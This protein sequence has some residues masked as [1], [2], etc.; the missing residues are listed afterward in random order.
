MK[1]KA[2]GSLTVTQLQSRLDS[3]NTLWS[4]ANAADTD[5]LCHNTDPTDPYLDEVILAQFHSTY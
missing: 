4:E 1:D 2:T 3:F 5:I